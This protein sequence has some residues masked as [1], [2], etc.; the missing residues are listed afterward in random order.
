MRGL[1]VAALL[2]PLSLVACDREQQSVV[3]TEATVRPSVPPTA[4]GAPGGGGIRGEVA[5]VAYTE[6]RNELVLLDAIGAPT[7]QRFTLPANPVDVVGAGSLVAVGF[8]SGD[9]AVLNI[10]SGR[11]V[12]RATVESVRLPQPPIQVIV[13][14]LLATATR[15]FVAGRFTTAEGRDYEGFVEERNIGDLA[16]VKTHLI[17]DGVVQD[18]EADAQGRVVTLLDDGRVYQLGEPTAEASGAGAR[19][20]FLAVGPG[21]Q[22]W[23]VTGG[24]TPS[25]RTPSGGQLALPPKSGPA[26]IVVTPSGAAVVLLGD[27]NAVWIVQRDGTVTGKTEVDNLPYAVALVKRR[28]LVGQANGNSLVTLDAMTGQRVAEHQVGRAV[29]LFAITPSIAER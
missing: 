16:Y 24:D 20:V 22:R 14:Q 7:G 26:G 6:G 5:A 18:L 29:R 11:Q 25:V 1:F 27:A 17:K 10:G 12:A 9:L 3:T 19:A 21:S 28:V 4:F 15:V 8:P 13:D 2:L 23:I